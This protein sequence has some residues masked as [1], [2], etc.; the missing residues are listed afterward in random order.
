MYPN[1]EQSKM[2]LSWRVFFK[3][4]FIPDVVASVLWPF[5]APLWT[6]SFIIA[7]FYSACSDQYI[8][9]FVASNIRESRYNHFVR[10]EKGLKGDTNTV[11][12][13]PNDI[14]DLKLSAINEEGSLIDSLDIKGALGTI[15]VSALPQEKATQLYAKRKQETGY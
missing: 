6:I 14:G 15:K 2:S 9:D 7:K 3:R 11:N 10:L 1:I 13:N 4:L 5:Y 12:G 8:R